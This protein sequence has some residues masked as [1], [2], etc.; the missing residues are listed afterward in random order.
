MCVCVCVCGYS[1]MILLPSYVRQG[2]FGSKFDCKCWKVEEKRGLGARRVIFRSL[3]S[4]ID[5]D[6]STEVSI[7][8]QAVS[9]EAL[10]SHCLTHSFIHL[11]S[12]CLTLTH[13]FTLTHSTIP[14]LPH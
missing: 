9:I 11:L 1:V 13:S 2:Q 5:I 3:L 10:Y 7:K 8:M 12:S 14:S 6:V 4:C